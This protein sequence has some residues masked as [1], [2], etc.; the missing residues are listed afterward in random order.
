MSY[1]DVRRAQDR[2]SRGLTLRGHTT[3]PDGGSKIP[4]AAAYQHV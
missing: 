1:R 3:R 4:D 2:C